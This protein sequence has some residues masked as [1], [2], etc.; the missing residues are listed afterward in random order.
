MSARHQLL[1]IF[2]A[3]LLESAR[4]YILNRITFHPTTKCWLWAGCND[5]RYGHAYFMGTRFKAHV[6]AYLAFVGGYHSTRVL[7][8][9]GCDRT[10]CCCP[11]HLSP[12]TQSKNMK[13]CFAVGR[14]RSPFLKVQHE[15]LTNA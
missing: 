14:G 11:D 15:Q 7:D 1:F 4:Q 3:L 13:R 8:H 6:L 12:V 9:K 5:G 10:R 2:Y